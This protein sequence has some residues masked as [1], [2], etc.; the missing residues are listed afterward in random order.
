M[1]RSPPAGRRRECGNGVGR[2]STANNIIFGNNGDDQIHGGGGSDQLTG[3]AGRD[4][5]FGE[6]GSDTL[7]ARDGEADFLSGGFGTDTGQKDSSDSNIGVEKF[8]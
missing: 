8:I 6:D 2:V 5:L 7:F 1:K 4:A 3:G